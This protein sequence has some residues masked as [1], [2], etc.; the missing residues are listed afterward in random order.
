MNNNIDFNEDKLDLVKSIKTIL[1]RIFNLELN[2][3]DE[4]DLIYSF[5]VLIFDD[6]V[7][8]T[9][10]PMLKVTYMFNRI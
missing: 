1:E 6:L 8:E 5:K 9:I 7:Y 3:G 4:E 2:E 10:S